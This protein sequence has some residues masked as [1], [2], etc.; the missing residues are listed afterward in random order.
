MLNIK[1]TGTEMKTAFDEFISRLD[2]TEE[3]Y[4][5]AGVY[6]SRILKHQ[7]NREQRLKTKNQNIIS[8]DWGTTTKGVTYA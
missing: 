1:N 2:P 8:E 4:L 3:K 6:I 7:K 5:W